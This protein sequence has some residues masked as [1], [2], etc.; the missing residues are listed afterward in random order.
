MVNAYQQAKSDERPKAFAKGYDSGYQKGRADGIE[1]CIEIILK[2]MPGE[3]FI[4]NS[5]H[6][7]K[8]KMK[9]TELRML[10]DM[11]EQLKGAEK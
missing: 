9:K 1:K 5:K 7:E 10:R 2:L 4:K 11:F 6:Y 3:P 8:W